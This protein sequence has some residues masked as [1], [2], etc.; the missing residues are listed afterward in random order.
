M[1][2]LLRPAGPEDLERLLPLVGD[3]HRFEGIAQSDAERRRI[4]GGLLGDPALGRVWAVELDG[5]LAGYLAL[6]FGY[7]LELGGRD[8]FLDELYLVESA[9]GRGVGRQV[10]DELLA[11]AAALGLRALHLEVAVSGNEAARR[12]YA[13]A[14]FG[15]RSRYRVLTRVLDGGGTAE[16]AT[17]RLRAVHPVLASSDVGRSLAFYTRLGFVELFRDTPES[18]RYAAVGR[19]GVELH[20]QWHAAS[21]FDPERDRPTYRLL[22]QEVD[23]L[24]AELTATAA[25]DPSAPSPSPWAKPGDTPWGTREFHLRD[26]DGNGLQFYQASEPGEPR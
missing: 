3:Y 20:L 8:G 21:D 15:E 12:L 16:R 18:P 23:A 22:V 5:D 19:D 4:F 17:A 10:V 1:N 6:A 26:P 11:E 2:R 9:R 13:R 7:S 25:I 24:F 14:G